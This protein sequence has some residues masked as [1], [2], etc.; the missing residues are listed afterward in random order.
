VTEKLFWKDMYL[1]EFEATVTGVEGNVVYLDR[2]AF[3]PTGGGQPSDTGIIVSKGSTYTVVNVEKS[4]EDVAHTLGNSEGLSIGDEVKGSL[5]W[6]RRYAHMRYHS[7]IHVIDGIFAK[8][9]SQEG[10]LTGGQIY[11]DRARI[12]IDMSDYS[13]EKIEEIIAQCNSFMREGHSIYQKFISRDEALAIE[14][15]S[16]TAPGRELIGKLENVRVIVIDG[17]D[18]Q[19]DGGTHVRDTREIGTI[20]IRKIENKGKRNKRIDF[21]L[22]R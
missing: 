15:L 13:R 20:R 1:G 8:L 19:A 12:D 17:L 2:T 16:R 5:D 18:E 4:G 6:E 14:N 22:E 11:Q 7:A 3:Y 10:F 9:H 21:V